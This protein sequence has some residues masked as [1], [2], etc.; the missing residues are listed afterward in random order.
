MNGMLDEQKIANRYNAELNVPRIDFY[1]TTPSWV[2]PV[3]HLYVIRHPRRDKLQN[4]LQNLGVGTLIHYPKPPH[5]QEAYSKDGFGSRKFPIAEALANEV[6]SLPMGPA[7]N[8][9]DI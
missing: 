9:G 3:W 2:D 1:W 6:L 8:R 4:A 5:Q 7:L